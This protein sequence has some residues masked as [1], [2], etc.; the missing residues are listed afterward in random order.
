ME[1]QPSIEEETAA[2]G[3]AVSVLLFAFLRRREANKQAGIPFTF[4]LHERLNCCRLL[5][6]F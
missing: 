2:A 5:R 1:Q 4:T 6:A 3:T